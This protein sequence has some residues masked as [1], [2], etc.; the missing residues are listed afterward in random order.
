MTRSS[1]SPLLLPTTTPLQD[2]LTLAPLPPSYTHDGP[3]KYYSVWIWRF[4]IFSLT[5]SSSLR[6]C[7]VMLQHT[8]ISGLAYVL[9]V[10]VLEL[11]CVYPLTLFIFG[12]LLGQRR[13]FGRVLY[14]GWGAW[15][16]PL[17]L[18]KKWVQS[19]WC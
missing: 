6:L 11:V 10:T 15:L 5:G 13:F 8:A 14:K 9:L 18:K 19:G 4:V 17:S 7:N 3:F 16:L 2:P 1:E 12:T